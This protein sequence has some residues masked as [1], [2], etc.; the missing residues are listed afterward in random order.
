MDAILLAVISVENTTM[1]AEAA[2][3]DFFATERLSRLFANPFFHG[4]KVIYQNGDLAD[5]N[6]IVSRS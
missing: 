6:N 1:L 2:S 5:G 4:T 3:G